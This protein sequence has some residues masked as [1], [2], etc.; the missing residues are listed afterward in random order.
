MS[1]H[2][3]ATPQIESTYPGSSGNSG[4]M[5]FFSDASQTDANLL[6][7]C[8]LAWMV[9]V[10][11]M[12][13]DSISVSVS[14]PWGWETYV[15][16]T[17]DVRLRYSPR[18]VDGTC[19]AGY[20]ELN[21]ICYE[22]DGCLGQNCNDSAG[23]ICRDIIAPLDGFLCECPTGWFFDNVT[24]TDVDDCVG[25]TC[26]AH[27]SCVDAVAP[28][29]GSSCNCQTGYFDDHGVCNNIDGCLD[30]NFS[31]MAGGDA[32]SAC[33][34]I[35]APGVGYTCRCSTGYN[36][37]STRCVIQSCGTPTSPTGYIIGGGTSDYQ[38]LR[39][40][41]C[42]TG[43]TGTA[44]SITCQ[45]NGSWTSST[46]CTIR[47]CP[48][49]SQTGYTINSGGSTYQ[50]TRTCICAT[51][52]LGTASSIT[53]TAD[54]SWTSSQGCTIVNCNTPA[55]GTGYN[56]G[57]GSTTYGS[58][59]TLTCATGYSGTASSITCQSSGSWTTPS[60][61]TIV[62]CTS[63]PTQ[64]N[65]VIS[66][67]GS[68]YLSTR[69]VTCATGYT[70]TP[71]SI[72][73]QAST[74]WTTSSGCTIRDCGNP[75]TVTGYS[76]ASGGTTY[77]STRVVSCSSGYGGSPPVLTCDS[78]GAW[79]APS[80]C[81]IGTCGEPSQTGYTFASGSTTYGSTRTA[82]CAT[83]YTGTPSGS[84]TCQ[85]SLAWTTNS[86]CTIR[87]C[88]TPIAD[89]GYVLGSGATTY[90]STYSMSCATG[91]RGTAV[92]L[93]CQSNGTWSAQSGCTILNCGTPVAGTG[94]AL[95]SGSTTYAST[96]SMTC[97]T[98]YSG[99][100]ASLTCQSN[101]TWSAQSGCTIRNCGIPSA[102]PGYVVGTASSTTYG[103][104]CSMT[105]AT[106]YSGTAASLSCQSSG[107]WSAQSGCT[108]IS[109]GTPVAGTG[110]A[111]G[112][113]STT[114]GSVFSMTCAAGYT[115]TASSLT[116]QASGSW[117]VQ[118]GCTIVNCGPPSSETGYS[119][120]SG[121]TTYGS[122]LSMTCATGCTGAA[123]TRTCQANG[124]WTAN[125]G[126][127]CVTRQ[128]CWQHKQ[129][130]PSLASGM[131]WINP[132]GA[133]AF[134]AYCDMTTDGG[135]WTM[136]HTS[137]NQ[138]N[139]RDQYSYT[140]TYGTNGYRT[141]CRNHF[142]QELMYV[143]HDASTTA[144][145]VAQ[146]NA[147]FT[148][149]GL[150]WD[151]RASTLYT[152]R[153]TASTSYSYQLL[154]CSNG[155]MP[156]GFFMSGYTGSCYKQ[157]GSWC[158]DMDSPYFRYN[159]DTGSSYNGV[160]FNTN[161]HRVVSY[162]T[163]SV[164]LRN[165]GVPLSMPNIYFWHDSS[166]LSGSNGAALSTFPNSAAGISGAY[167]GTSTCTGVIL[168]G[169]KNGLKT[170]TISTS[171]SYLGIPESVVINPY[172][173]VWV[174]RQTGTYGR[175]LTGSSNA[176]YGY[177]GG[178]KKSFYSNAN[179][180]LHVSGIP[181]DN[182]WDYFVAT[183]TAGSS[184]AMRWNSVP[185][186]SGS[187]SESQ[188]M[189]GLGINGAAPGCCGGERSS[190]EIAEIILYQRVLSTSEI[191]TLESYIRAKSMLSCT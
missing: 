156:T 188:G 148:A 166:Q 176:L 126:C 78:T 26:G 65:Y 85:S 123:A 70:G 116:C 64:T 149:A 67:G 15:D 86:G 110:Y 106:G 18:D 62:S 160:S 154:I 169:G 8:P 39:S 54:G 46:G 25:N 77:Q 55:P 129:A 172:T 28:D 41:L 128:D 50:A 158:S 157:C 155:W 44:T 111:N 69:T 171:Q 173:L 9:A 185:L 180:Q 5:I 56:L 98:G 37:D 40:V 112:S 76:I 10:K 57:S 162:I 63:S 30:Y 159:G 170:V 131:Y 117:T 11:A 13:L 1:V 38:D 6:I 43:Y 103:S 145:F 29:T 48:T 152:A 33:V 81:T 36:V 7:A 115:G 68:T 165:K 12:C 51:G 91:Y 74:A 52:Y 80:G 60:G 42:A 96:Y 71:S 146:N 141:D 138:V 161:G 83:G 124:T 163:M 187:T 134:L 140:G 35:A 179:P 147:A 183:R 73:C 100:A 144:L 99:T 45:S 174:G 150:G 23:G 153:T 59:Y 34:D 142:F 31:C 102:S 95:G 22:T 14:L 3:A 132:N 167:T 181:S 4:T 108:I 75:A 84:I 151:A 186:Y 133:G 175:V 87:N 94:Y 113:G 177:W 178:Y 79:N 120:G 114:Y 66:S 17:N 101:G 72:T 119:V 143:N 118:A 88:G 82:S 58:S 47:S 19:S 107:S 53:C 27:G 127:T 130:A 105:C 109:C 24:C 97:S 191:T 92:T 93:T 16:H 2:I 89:T 136:C 135:G 190:A 125:A 139:I 137:N 49:P 182:L 32:N 20:S 121:G 90:G 104:T 21:S 164:G 168:A 122:T 61:C 184:F 189:V